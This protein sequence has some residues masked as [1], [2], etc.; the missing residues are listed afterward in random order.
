MIQRKG[1]GIVLGMAALAYL[2]VA[3]VGYLVPT[4]SL[5]ELL[6]V[7]VLFAA[8]LGPPLLVAWVGIGTYP[9]RIR[10]HNAYFAY[11]LIPGLIG[12]AVAL[13][14]YALAG[15]IFLGVQAVYLRTP[16]SDPLQGGDGTDV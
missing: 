5:P 8:S 3:V 6:V 14:S 12:L 2:S 7:V 16:T 11:A 1:T 15:F 4:F 10:T 9:S 13:E